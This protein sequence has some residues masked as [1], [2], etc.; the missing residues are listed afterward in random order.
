M[1]HDWKTTSNLERTLSVAQHGRRGREKQGT[2]E[3]GRPELRG[4]AERQTGAQE[5]DAPR[6]KADRKGSMF[7][8]QL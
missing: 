8:K 6:V 5:R 7:L 1:S 4:N 3:Q 2:G